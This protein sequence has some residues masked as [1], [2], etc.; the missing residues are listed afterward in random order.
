VHL[1]RSPAAL[2]VAAL[3][4]AGMA[5]LGTLPAS[6]QTTGPKT[7]AAE[8]VT[9]TGQAAPSAKSCPPGYFCA[10]Q[11]ANYSGTEW[12]YQE[13][14]L[15]HP[16]QWRPVWAKAGSEVPENSVNN[17]FSSFWDN[18]S[19]SV[20]V[21]GNWPDPTS[22]PKTCAGVLPHVYRSNLGQSTW[23]N[24]G[25]VNNSISSY[26]ISTSTNAINLKNCNLGFVGSK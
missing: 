5:V 8:T 4:S 14:S 24:G 26:E 18:G 15:V 2:A 3:A 10:W 22:N 20:Y 25:S 19:V 6:A 11:N 21:G 23:P 17:Q 1:T 13:K 12:E 16:V 7:G 9:E